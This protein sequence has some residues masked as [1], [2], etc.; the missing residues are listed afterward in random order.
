MYFSKV[1]AALLGLAIGIQDVAAGPCKPESSQTLTEGSLGATGSVSDAALTATSIVS[2]TETT[3]SRPDNDNSSTVSLDSSSAEIASATTSNTESVS[4]ATESSE[5]SAAL[6]STTKETTESSIS[7]EITILPSKTEETPSTSTAPANEQPQIFTGGFATWVYQNGI[8]GGCGSVS[9]DTDFVAA[10]DYRRYD[11]SK[12]G[13][14]ICVTATSGRRVGL[15][16]DVIVD[17]STS[18]NPPRG[19][20]SLSS[21]LFIPDIPETRNAPCKLESTKRSE[22]STQTLTH[23]DLSSFPTT[24]VPLST[25]TPYAYTAS[26]LPTTSLDWTSVE[27]T[28]A[29]SAT[30]SY[31]T[32]EILD[33]STEL[34]STTS[35]ASAG[36]SAPAGEDPQ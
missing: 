25:N 6:R 20:Q 28:L 14:K 21:K 1:S 12:C 2:S 4:T 15:S 30:A 17:P 16:I 31:E 11:R 33:S 19:I 10:L 26:I 8:L 35:S 34:A 27:T 24:D 13:R 5:T 36:E 22:S 18:P 23:S 9:Q 29:S 7:T 3:H 32:T